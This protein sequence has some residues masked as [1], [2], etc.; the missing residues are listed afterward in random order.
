MYIMFT[1]LFSTKVSAGVENVMKIRHGPRRW[2]SW[3]LIRLVITDV[4]TSLL[5]NVLC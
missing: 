1:S 2:S 4:K 3:K 5:T